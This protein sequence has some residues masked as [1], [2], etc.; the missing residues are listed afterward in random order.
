MSKKH[1]KEVKTENRLE[2]IEETLTKTEQFIV[3]NQKVIYIVVAV[4]VVAILGYF[5][6]QKYYMKPKTLEAQEQIYPAQRYFAA[7]SL[8]KA[9]YGDG[10]NLGFVEIAKDYSITKPGNLANYYA[11]MCFLR[12]GNFDQAISYLSAFDGDDEIVSSM[13][14]GGI[15]DAYLEK[16]KQDKA[17]SYYK[18]AAE[19]TVNDFT[20]PLFLFKAGEIYEAQK[21]YDKA[22]DIYKRIK[23]EYF[24]SKEGRQIERY[25]GRVT[26]EKEK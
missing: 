11:G 25:I 14:I 19:N 12:K 23:S 10:N 1:Q 26:A 9:L 18:K 21:K 24:S 20:T 15:G 8:D 22:L 4:I 16:G 2:N 3:N 6:W 17:I 13:A 7:D 5:A